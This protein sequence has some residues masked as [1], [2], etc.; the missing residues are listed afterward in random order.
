MMQILRPYHQSLK[1]A[2]SAWLRL[3]VFAVLA[4]VSYLHG[5]SGAWAEVADAHSTADFDAYATEVSNNLGVLVD[6]FCYVAFIMG[7]VSIGLGLGEMRRLADGSGGGN[8]AWRQPLTKLFFGGVFLCIP[9]FTSL[10]QST[11]GVD[12]ATF[13]PHNLMN[14][15]RLGSPAAIEEQG[16]GAIMTKGINNIGVLVQVVTVLGFI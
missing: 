6:V 11:M 16:L 10:A 2:N 13:L 12:G 1:T 7:T 4:L 3:A 14:S 5:T 15:Y 8:L 9:F